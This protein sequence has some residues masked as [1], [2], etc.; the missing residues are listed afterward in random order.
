[1]AYGALFVPL[2]VKQLDGG[3]IR[4]LCTIPIFAFCVSQL[5]AHVE[6]SKNHKCIFPLATVPHLGHGVLSEALD[7]RSSYLGMVEV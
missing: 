6:R 2:R 3:V 5:V 4:V 7:F 1:M